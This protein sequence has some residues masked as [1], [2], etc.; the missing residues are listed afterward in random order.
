MCPDCVV[1]VEDTQVANLGVKLGQQ[2][3]TLLRRNPDVNFVLPTYDAQG[4]YVVPAI[5]AANFS[6][7]IEVIGSDAVP[8]N[9]DWIR[10]RQHPGR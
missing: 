8:S 7:P 5:K 2:V 1:T 6:N 10:A 3:Q 4:I 9:L